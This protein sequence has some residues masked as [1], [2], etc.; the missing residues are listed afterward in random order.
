MRSK[1]TFINMIVSFS[2]FFINNIFSFVSKSIFIVYLGIEYSGLNA[3]LLNILGVLNLAE[4]GISTS[5]GYALYKPLKDKNNEKI[6]EILYLFKKLYQFIGIFIFLIGII[7]SFFLDYLVTSDIPIYLIRMYFLLYLFSVLTSYF[8]TYTNVLPASDQKN[9]IVVKIQG[10]VK[11]VKNI[12]ELVIV[13]IFS[14]Y[15]LWLV[16]EIMGNIFS[17]ILC[18]IKV[19]NMYKDIN[20]CNTFSIK[21]LL[22]KYTDIVEN[23]KNLFF[24]QIGSLVV[25]QTDNIIISKFC[26]LVA[27][28]KYTNYIYIYQLLTGCIDQV[29]NSITSSIGN[30]IVE[31]ETNKKSYEIWKTIYCFCYF[32]AILFS[33]LF[34]S[35]SQDFVEL[36]V[37]KEN[38]LANVTIL[39]ISFNIFF[40]IIKSPTERFKVAYG[41]FQDRYAPFIEAIINLV[42]SLILVK[43]IG[44]SGVVLGTVISNICII[45]FWKPYITFKE[46]F[47]KKYI[48]YLFISTKLML[49]GLLGMIVSYKLITVINLSVFTW[50][51]LIIEFIVLS[52]VA[53][54]VHFLIF[55]ANKDFRQSFKEIY[56]RIKMIVRGGK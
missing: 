20:F 45:Y 53:T 7:L 18:N 31:D 41:I 23:I 5:V 42:F 35:L 8:L 49:I 6:E 25:N 22:K 56:S 55:F 32:V 44:V 34:Y 9:Y 10:N 19:K 15:I 46:G 52:I 47:K 3:F 51:D 2:Y 48:K 30:L 50:L 43:K 1:K 40:R 28:G 36:W 4:L 11:I 38:T 27:V 21:K 16:V 29:F 17:Y 54:V 26:D 24:H 37:G 39:F 14:N 12:I 13:I 33:F